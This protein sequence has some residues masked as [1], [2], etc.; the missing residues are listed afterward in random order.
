MFTDALIPGGDLH[1]PTLKRAGAVLIA[2]GLIDIGVMAYCIAN[3]ISYASSFNV[4]SV[5]AG[6]FLMRGS[7]RAAS[8]VRSTCVFLLCGVAAMAVAWPFLQPWDL[9]VAQLRQD[10][11]SAMLAAVVLLALC[12][13]MGWLVVTLG[14]PSVQAAQLASGLRPRRLS[15]PMAA[16]LGVVLLLGL[17]A[18]I[19]LFGESASKAKALAAQQ[20]GD[21]YRYHVS[22]L[23]I[24]NTRDGT[25][26][27]AVV[28]A[29][30]A[31]EIRDLP[32]AWQ[33]P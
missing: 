6:V 16:G 1:V 20:L 30:N 8:I 32:V 33:E 4:F 9:T 27:K 14:L 18:H 15:V 21:A 23:S 26:V 17:S 11:G 29:W 19:F 7:L 13:L 31:K 28:T 25:T 24:A 3:E 12:A 5:V 10:A 22:S 2:V